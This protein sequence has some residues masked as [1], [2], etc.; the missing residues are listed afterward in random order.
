MIAKLRPVDYVGAAVFLALIGFVAFA[1]MGGCQDGKADA[2]FIGDPVAEGAQIFIDGEPVGV[3]RTR[4][5]DGQPVPWLETRVALG[6]H[7]LLAV[8]ARGDSMSAD[9]ESHESG[10][11][12]ITFPAASVGP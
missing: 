1:F 6:T 5:V 12:K 4:D 9:Y 10:S 7:K 2:T 3:M 11:A 8:S